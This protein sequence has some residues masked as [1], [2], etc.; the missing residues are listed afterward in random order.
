MTIVYL[1]AILPGCLIGWFIYKLDK[2][3]KEPLP[4][5]I[6]SFLLGMLGTYP[7]LK[8]QQWISQ[9]SLQPEDTLGDLLFFSFV[10]VALSEELVK[11]IILRVYAFPKNAFNEPLDG[12]VYAVMIGMGF[13]TLENIIY[14]H[15]YGIETI[16]IRAFTAVPAHGIFAVIMGYFAGLAKF[17][18]KSFDTGMLLLTGLIVSIIAHGLYNF[19]I[20]QK[21]H[22]WLILLTCS[23]IFLS[24]MLTYRLILKQRSN[25]P[26]F[27]EKQ[28]KE[29]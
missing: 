5:L 16:L 15:V 23:I 2:Y 19:F 25:S 12:I 11:F 14:A 7:P 20:I 3:D 18:S 6:T 4:Y 13:A 29:T 21:Y 27:P 24:M 26:L 28:S 17:R 9:Y 10:V 1:L 22:E 8:F